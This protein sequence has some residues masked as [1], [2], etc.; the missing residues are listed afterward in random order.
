MVDRFLTCPEK[1]MILAI[2]RPDTRKNLKG[3]VSAYGNNIGLQEMANLVI[4]AGNREDIRDLGEAQQKVLCDLLLDVDR[5]DLWGKV[6]LPK[7]HNCEDVPEFYRI[8]ARR[9]GIFVNTALTEP[10]GL[11]LIEA[12]AS[13]LPFVATE[14][15]GPRDIVANCRNGLLINPLDEIAIAEALEL[16]LSDS[17]QWRLWAKNGLNGVRRHYSWDAHIA[18]YMKAVRHLLY[19][20]RKRLRRQLATRQAEKSNMLLIHRILVSDID[21]TLIGHRDG[22]RE[23]TEW[24]RRHGKTVAFGIATGRTLESAVKILRT[25]RAPLPD[26]LITSVGS[27]IN[28]GPRLHPDVG[29]AK[30]IS[31]MWR[32]EALEDAL[33]NIPG[34]ELQSAENQREFKLSYN[35]SLDRMPSLG[36]LYGLLN[37]H[38]LHARLILS[39]GAFLDVLPVRASKGHA[40]RYL[41]YKWGIPLRSFLVAGDSGND[42]EMLVGDTLGVVVG[43]HSP[44]LAALRGQEQI[45]FAEG[46]CAC[47]IL[48]GLRYYGF[49]GTLPM[50]REAA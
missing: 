44:E 21:N 1:P 45:Y 20:D 12:A 43:N 6:A 39:H 2:C 10:F 34:L 22:L 41:A 42:E 25:W 50:D 15:G 35:V 13:G 29:W 49:D 27:E 28:Y 47:G 5:Y 32:R 4:V 9:R 38:H 30:H 40:I 48:E 3:L 8:A 16:A 11:T 37:E 23:L 19:R 24:L 18:K 14:D 33:S 17:K 26:V 7:H 36:H 31:H 46:F